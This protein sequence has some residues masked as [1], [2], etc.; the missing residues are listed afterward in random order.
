MS[1]LCFYRKASKV[2]VIPFRVLCARREPIFF[3]LRYWAVDGH[4]CQGN[5]EG[6]GMKLKLFFL[7]RVLVFI[8]FLAPVRESNLGVWKAQICFPLFSHLVN[9]STDWQYNHCGSRFRRVRLWAWPDLLLCPL[10]WCPRLGLC[11]LGDR[12]CGAGIWQHDETR[13]GRATGFLLLLK[14]V[15]AWQGNESRVY[16]LNILYLLCVLFH[17]HW[18]EICSL[19]ELLIKA[20]TYREFSSVGLSWLKYDIQYIPGTHRSDNRELVSL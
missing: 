5:T 11:P 15:S 9:K 6:E 17:H 10:W 3:T 14:Q 2:Q 7:L 4:C 8:G 18:F 19:E 16:I 20:T 13:L 12:W 1:R